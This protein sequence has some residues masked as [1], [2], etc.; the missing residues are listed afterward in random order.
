MKL[1]GMLQTL[2]LVA[3]LV[4]SAQ[5]RAAETRVSGLYRQVRVRKIDLPTGIFQSP[6]GSVY[7]SLQ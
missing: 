7:S 1:S 4:V 3:A 2:L 5:L 6:A